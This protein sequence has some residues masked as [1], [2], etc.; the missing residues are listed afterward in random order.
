[1]KS[2]YVTKQY[3]TDPVGFLINVLDAKKKRLET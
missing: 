2:P 1:M 3:K